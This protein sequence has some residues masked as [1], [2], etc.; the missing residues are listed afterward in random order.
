MFVDS[1]DSQTTQSAI[2]AGVTAYVIDGLNP[3][4]VRPIVDV[5]IARFQEH[6]ALRQELE[7]TKA[8]LNERKII[9]RAKGLLMKE[10]GMD[11]DEAYKLLRTQ[12]MAQNRRLVDVAQA[13]LTYADMLKP[14][15]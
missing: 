14:R 11:E 6:R 12:A 7:K 8:S 4:R 10:R 13:L 3:K 1:S 5:A 9:D 2:R 15:R